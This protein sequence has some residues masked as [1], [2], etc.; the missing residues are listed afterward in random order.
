[1]RTQYHTDN[2]KPCWGCHGTIATYTLD[3]AVLL[4]D[5][6]CL[7]CLRRDVFRPKSPLAE[8]TAAAISAAHREC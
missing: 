3:S 1:M 2:G 8:Q 5:V 6:Q 4:I 7:S